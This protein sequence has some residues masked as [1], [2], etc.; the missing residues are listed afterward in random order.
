[1]EP[2]EHDERWALERI[3]SHPRFAG[4]AS[5]ERIRALMAALGDPQKALRF[6]HIAGTN[7]KGSVAAMTANALTHAGHRTGLYISPFVLCFRERMQIDGQM[8]PPGELAALTEEVEER[9][10]GL[11]AGEFEYVTALALTWFARRGCDVVVLEVGLGGRFD[12]TNVIDPPLVQ[13]ITRLGLDHT[14]ILGGAIEQIAQEKA[15]IIKGGVTVVAPHQPPEA[16]AELYARCAETGGTLVQP[17]IGPVERLPS[18][19]PL[20]GEVFDYGGLRLH[21]SL[22]G[23]HQIDNA[24]TAVEVCRQLRAQGFALPDEAIAWGIAHTV[25]PARMEVLA[26]RPLVVLDGA[27]NPDGMRALAGMLDRLRAAGRR[28]T[29]LMGMLADKDWTHAVELAAR[30]ADRL[31]AVTPDNPRALPG[32]ELA[33]TAARFCADAAASEDIPQSAVAIVESL[34][35]RDA[36]VCCGS[37]YLAAELRPVLLGLLGQ[38]QNPTK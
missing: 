27:H 33:A 6:V 18:D 29:L 9:A 16:L 26:R 24:I 31:V 21:P 32:S 23:E 38:N 14:A 13:V 35:E 37:L 8:I 30:R 7:G 19:D 34:R 4:A 2:L 10:G 11:A 22:P 28:V 17:G 1:M 36:L 5:L 12:A 20:G 25:F 15:G 3:H